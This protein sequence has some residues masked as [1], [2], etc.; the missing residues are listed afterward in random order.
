M[1]AKLNSARG[2]D[3][4]SKSKYYQ[5]LTCL[6]GQAYQFTVNY[7]LNASASRDIYG[8][9]ERVCRVCAQQIRPYS[10]NIG[11]IVVNDTGEWPIC[12]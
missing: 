5:L 9:S 2:G 11:T 3:S 6:H 7:L 10:V 4:G 1:R 12:T 8:K